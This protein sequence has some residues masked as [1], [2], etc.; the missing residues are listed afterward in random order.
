[1]YASEGGASSGAG[2]GTQALVG[3]GILAKGA[4]GRREAGLGCPQIPAASSADFPSRTM[5]DSVD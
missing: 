1:M 4:S 3:R 2:A 5:V